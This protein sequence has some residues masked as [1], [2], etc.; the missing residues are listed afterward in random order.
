M[1]TEKRVYNKCIIKSKVT[2]KRQKK[3]ICKHFAD[4]KHRTDNDAEDDKAHSPQTSV[5]S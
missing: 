5:R 3:T 1:Q 4:K 2:S